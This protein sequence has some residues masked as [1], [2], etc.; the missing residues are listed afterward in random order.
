MREVEFEVV[1]RSHLAQD[2]VKTKDSCGNAKERGGEIF[3]SCT[4]E[5]CSKGCNSYFVL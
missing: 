1:E 3:N 5:F 2:S 4:S